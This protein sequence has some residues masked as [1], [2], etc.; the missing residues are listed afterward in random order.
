MRHTAYG[1]ILLLAALLS[2][3]DPVWAA[4]RQARQ[5]TDEAI[6]DARLALRSKRVGDAVAT[7]R[8]PAERGDPTASFLLGLVLESE[9][10]DQ[11]EADAARKYLRIAAGQRHAG[12]AFALAGSLATR[13]PRDLAEARHWLSVAATLG[14]PLATDLVR[15]SALPYAPQR[16][17]AEAPP[18]LRRQ[19]ALWTV[20]HGEELD[21]ESLPLE[22]L[23]AMRDEQG[24]G[25]IAVAAEHG[26]ASIVSRL[27]T[28][29]LDCNQSDRFGMTPL[30]LAARQSD[31]AT[32][33]ALLRAGAAPDA[34]D[35]V[36]R[37]AL[38]HAAWTDQTGQ[39]AT[40]A[41]AGAA[42]DKFDSRGWSALDI[43]LRRSSASTITTLRT[44]GVPTRATVP[45]ERALAGVDT[46]RPG[47]LY[48]NWPA[49]L[50]A[51]SRDDVP[52]VQRELA[53]DPGL[54]LR[55]PQGYRAL[56]VAVESGARRSVPLLLAAG[57]DPLAADTNAESPVERAIR[58]RDLSTLELLDSQGAVRNAPSPRREAW[59]TAA[60]TRGHADVASWLLAHGATASARDIQG[61]PALVLAVIA[62]N[63]DM[64]RQLLA[65][66]APVDSLDAH[67]RSALWH[68]AAIGAMEPL[69]QLIRSGAERDRPDALGATPLMVAAQT[70]QL[71]ALEALIA[72]DASASL[73]DRAGD[74]ALHIA[75]AN[76]RIGIVRRLLRAGLEINRRNAAGDTPLIVAARH[77]HAEICESL[78][79][80][81]ADAT[82]RN[83]FGLTARDVAELRGFTAVARAIAAR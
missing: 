17:G 75:A 76:G 29:G 78:L 5:I 41:A 4:A 43:A 65:A 10:L 3:P 48:A 22:E 53:A 34:Q 19:F 7:L 52:V 62:R 82:P 42:L 1:S 18:D 83:R 80:A 51:V 73:A 47:R 37:T 66:G 31:T 59:L 27:I 32:T 14:H 79:R 55:S 60:V 72:A 67:G 35:N 15:R 64:V 9:H 13:E 36:G 71:A 23:R 25:L 28:I 61:T 49:L 12:A 24:R 68:A 11:T 38:M 45:M 39:I 77:G 33:S 50:I 26:R 40:L 69:Q 63:G 54:G 20:A 58:R 81:G 74:T 57:H 70:G 21:L 30:M 6:E 16:P 46:T 56:D 2:V 8:E 44:L